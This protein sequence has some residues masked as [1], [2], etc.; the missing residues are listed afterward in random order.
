MSAEQR[1]RL[2]EIK[3][4]TYDDLDP[5]WQ[6]EDEDGDENEQ[7]NINSV[8]DVEMMEDVLGGEALF[9]TSHHGGEFKEILRQM[10]AELRPKQYVLHE[11]FI[12]FPDVYCT[13]NIQKRTQERVVTVQ[14]A[15]GKCSNLSWHGSSMH[16]WPGVQGVGTM[17]GRI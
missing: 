13:V 10:A 5:A 11:I 6:D 7:G 8:N 12:D 2:E 1:E 3:N 16:T 4:A 15:D 17:A 9:D 14:N